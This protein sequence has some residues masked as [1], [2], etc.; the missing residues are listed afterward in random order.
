M[1]KKDFTA[2]AAVCQEKAHK[3]LNESGIAEIWKDAGCRVNL[4][5]SLK[6]GLLASHRD[7]DL[8]VYSPG[9]TEES[10]FKIAARI[11]KIP[12]VT[13]IKCINGLNTEERCI[14]WHVRYKAKDGQEWTFDIIHIEEDSLYDGYFEKMA[15]RIVEVMTQEQR[16]TILRLKFETPDSE[17]IHGVEYYEAVIADG[18]SDLNGLRQWIA[19]HRKKKPYYW[20]P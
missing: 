14:A 4:V 2:L 20:M 9:I 18:I 11:A 10:S 8:H 3:V 12:D 19:D 5:G 17:I 16:Q 1:D 7:I 13:E 15:E 6:M